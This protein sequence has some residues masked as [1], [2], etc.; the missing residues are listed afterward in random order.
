MTVKARN[1]AIVY[2]QSG[3]RIPEDQFV[4]VPLSATLVRAVKLGDLEE[5]EEDK[6]AAR[7]PARRAHSED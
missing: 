3:T 1:G 6:P 7:R 4:T 2:D 5:A